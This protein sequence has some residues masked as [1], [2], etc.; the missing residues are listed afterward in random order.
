MYAV[1]AC[2]IS[3]GGLFGVLGKN[4]FT[5][6]TNPSPVQFVL[7]FL[8]MYAGP[9]AAGLLLTALTGGKKALRAMFS[10][11]RLRS[12]GPIWY[13]LAV[14][15]APALTLVTL[16]GLSRLSPAFMPALFLPGYDLTLLPMGIFF[17][18]MTG[19]FEELGWTGFAVPK[20]R[21]SRGVITTGLIVGGVWGL[22]HLPLF[23]TGDPAGTVPFVLLLVVRLFTQLP[24]FRVL[25]VWVYERTGSLPVAMV[26]HAGLTASSLIIT[27]RSTAGINTVI[28][29]LVL[30]A[31]V[32]IV[33]G[34][35]SIKRSRNSVKRHVYL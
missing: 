5:G 10:R 16:L 12:S 35:V 23:L 15:S 2:V 6:M 21:E 30:T 25:M 19:F 13:I 8:T 18:F 28:H 14:F 22:W 1:L 34:I 20:L 11:M 26:M 32:W 3:W 27:A 24:A 4:L 7:M 17:G 29:N 33:I 9:S 31:V